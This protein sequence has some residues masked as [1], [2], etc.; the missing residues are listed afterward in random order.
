[1]AR[2]YAETHA[3]RWYILSAAH[4]LVDPERIIDPYDISLNGRK[5]RSYGGV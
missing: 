2:R 5:C 3:E 4:G 1:M